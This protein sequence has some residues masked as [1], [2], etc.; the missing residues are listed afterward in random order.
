VRAPAGIILDPN[1][2]MFPLA[3]ALE[4][5]DPEAALVAAADEPVDDAARVV[6]PARATE[7]ERQVAERAVFVQVRVVDL[8]R[9]SDSLRARSG[10]ICIQ[11]GFTG[12]SPA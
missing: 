2:I 12:Y 10:S 8:D 3:A 4:I 6:S 5:D 9:M 1:N 11:Q 7:R